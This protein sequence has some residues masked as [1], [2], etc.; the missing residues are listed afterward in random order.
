M[1][2]AA[3]PDMIAIMPRALIDFFSQLPSRERSLSPGQFLFHTED[4]VGSVFWIDEGLVHLQRFTS[5]GT[6]AVMQRAPAGT[7]L[8]EASIFAVRYHCDAVAVGPV[9]ARQYALPEVRRAMRDRPEFAAA[10]AEHLAHEVMRMRSRSE[11]ASLRTVEAR[12]DAWLAL[13]NHEVPPRGRRVELA[14]EIGVSP[15][16]LYRELSRRRAG[17]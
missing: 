17:S 15:E 4:P 11:I 7:L 9:K 2:L 8:A 3:K 16:A 10:L 12:L 14:R 13:H 5:D 6:P 1:Q